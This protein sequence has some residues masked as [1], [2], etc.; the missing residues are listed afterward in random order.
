[1]RPLAWRM[2][3]PGHS[4]L[5]WA[6]M[7]TSACS[8]RR[9]CRT[10]RASLTLWTGQVPHSVL[11]VLATTVGSHTLLTL[12]A[13]QPFLVHACQ[14]TVSC[15]HCSHHGLTGEQVRA[16]VCKQAHWDPWRRCW[17][18]CGPRRNP[19]QSPPLPLAPS[20]GRMSCAQRSCWKRYAWRT[21]VWLIEH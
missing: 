17:N 7:T 10:W 6:R 19:S 3:W 15:M 21:P 8:K 4:C 13:P 2:R 9:S 14:M 1:M 18:F 5:W 20:I 11:H 16:S 12:S